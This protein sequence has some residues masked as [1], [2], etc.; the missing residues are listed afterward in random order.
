MTR[1]IEPK[2]LLESLI[3][4]AFRPAP[5]SCP[6]EASLLAPRP[7]VHDGE[8]DAVAAHVGSCPRCQASLA[9]LAVPVT[10]EVPEPMFGAAAGL[11][12]QHPVDLLRLAVRALVDRLD[13]VE[14]VG[15]M[16]QP[17]PVRGAGVD[18]RGVSV[19]RRMGGRDV[20]AHV[21]YS[22]LGG[23]AIMLDMGADPRPSRP[24]RVTVWRD[25]RELA[26]HVAHDG[27]AMFPSLRPG[28]YRMHIERHDRDQVLGRI[29]LDLAAP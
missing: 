16:L 4:A 15:A 2:T 1:P 3:P 24:L 14:L 17:R 12:T 19:H 5:R 25:D 8:Q 9:A 23:F 13:V 11:F 18:G 10:S 29:D 27:R 20:N 26:S 7:R 28:A 22:Q 21:S 6:D